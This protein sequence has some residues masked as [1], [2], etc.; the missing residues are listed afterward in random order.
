MTQF[1]NLFL[2]YLHFVLRVQWPIIK[3]KATVIIIIIII[4]I[5]V[6]PT[7]HNKKWGNVICLLST[8]LRIAEGYVTEHTQV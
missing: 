3:R 4:I 2:I 6:R 1:K 5:M 7:E 8:G